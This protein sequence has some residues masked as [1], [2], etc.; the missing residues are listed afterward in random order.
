MKIFV[1]GQTEACPY[2]TRVN[3]RRG[4]IY[5]AQNTK[6]ISLRL[7][8]EYVLLNRLCNR[9]EPKRPRQTLF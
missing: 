2:E 7:F 6:Y 3:I 4:E 1:S 8:D 5:L 9:R